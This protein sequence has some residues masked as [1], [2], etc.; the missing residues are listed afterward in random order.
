MSVFTIIIDSQETYH[1]S[2]GVEYSVEP[3]NTSGGL[4]LLKNINSV[5]L[6]PRT[7]PPCQEIQ[8]QNV[9]KTNLI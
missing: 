3:N 7:C 6:M 5:Q 9:I 1:I 2:I 4:Y 8:N